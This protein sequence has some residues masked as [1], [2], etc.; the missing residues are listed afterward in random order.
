MANT[1]HLHQPTHSHG[2]I[3]TSAAGSLRGVDQ[4]LSMLKSQRRSLVS[5]QACYDV[6]LICDAGIEECV[7][8]NSPPWFS[9][10]LVEEQPWPPQDWSLPPSP[11]DSGQT[12]EDV[13]EQN[14]RDFEQAKAE[15]Q[16][17]FWIWVGT[18]LAVFV[19][20]AC[21]VG[22]AAIFIRRYRKNRHADVIIHSTMVSNSE[23]KDAFPSGFAHA[24]AIPHSEMVYHHDGNDMNSPTLEDI[25]KD[26]TIKIN[27]GCSS[28]D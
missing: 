3:R 22:S 7:P 25:T 24:V 16:R 28:F 15:Q 2:M 21:S 6:G 17:I 1:Q 10:E 8:S 13:V 9:C 20:F 14:E 26:S 19:F 23:P 18:A 4:H 27:T 11:T 12:F 5:L